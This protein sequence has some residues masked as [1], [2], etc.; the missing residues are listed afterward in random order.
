MRASDLRLFDQL[1]QLDAETFEAGLELHFGDEPHGLLARQRRG[2][3]GGVS[4][5]RLRRRFSSSRLRSTPP[6][7]DEKRFV[8]RGDD[9]TIAPR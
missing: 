2:G 4:M 3:P 9:Q 6:T 5:A 8:D 1:A 7:D